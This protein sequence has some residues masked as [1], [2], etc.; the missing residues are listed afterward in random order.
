M[1]GLTLLYAILGTPWMYFSEAQHALQLPCSEQIARWDRSTL[2]LAQDGNS[3]VQAFS[4]YYEDTVQVD[5]GLTPPI[6]QE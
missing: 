6:A 4:A 2:V 1:T 5:D 3:N